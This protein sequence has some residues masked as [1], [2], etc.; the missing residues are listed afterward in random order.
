MRPVFKPRKKNARFRTQE[1]KMTQEG[2]I[3]DETREIDTPEGIESE[4]WGPLATYTGTG[5]G[6]QLVSI[7]KVTS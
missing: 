2:E 7:P 4:N 3:P 1:I 5:G 6:F